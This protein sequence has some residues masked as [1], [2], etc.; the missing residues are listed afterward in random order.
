MRFQTSTSVATPATILNQDGLVC[1]VER[2]EI[3]CREITKEE[4]P[5]HVWRHVNA[6]S[7]S[8]KGW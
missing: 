6:T 3:G 4:I 2:P 5:A 7:V 1:E 8:S